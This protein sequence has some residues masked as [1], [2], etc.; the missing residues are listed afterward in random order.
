MDRQSVEEMS[1]IEVRVMTIITFPKTSNSEEE[2]W[3]LEE[4]VIPLLGCLMEK[5]CWTHISRRRNDLNQ[6]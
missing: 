2:Y 6:T 5:K 1:D 3:K 4:P